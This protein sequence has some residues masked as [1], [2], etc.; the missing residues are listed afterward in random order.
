MQETRVWFLGRED[1]LEEEMV[2]QSSMLA[3]RIPWTEE[4]GRLQFVGSQ[5]QT[6]LIMH[7][8]SLVYLASL[9][10]HDLKFIYKMY[11]VKKK[12]RILGYSWRKGRWCKQE[13]ELG[14]TV[15]SSSSETSAFI[16]LFSP[17]FPFCSRTSPTCPP[18][19]LQQ[20]S[21]I[22]LKNYHGK[23][24]LILTGLGHF[25]IIVS[26]WILEG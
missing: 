24:F 17:H 13:A 16:M 3:W 15:T 22:F 21:A 19:T 7:R 25:R 1:P 20:S 4:P 18:T 11:N 14:R 9:I 2:T 6:W 23:S 10:Q 8:C 5:S 26:A 12:W